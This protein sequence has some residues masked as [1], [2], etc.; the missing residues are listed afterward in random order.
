MDY[1]YLISLGLGFVGG[2]LAWLAFQGILALRIYRLQLALATVQQAL[3]S[4]KTAGAARARWDKE[5]KLAQE[6]QAFSKAP[7]GPSADRFANDPIP[8]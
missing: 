3:L 6:L 4:V 7:S 8:Y 5:D 2:V 1:V